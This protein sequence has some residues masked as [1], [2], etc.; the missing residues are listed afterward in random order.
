MEDVAWSH[1]K[2]EEVRKG[3]PLEASERL[4][5]CPYLELRLVASRAEGNYEV[6]VTSHPAC[7]LC[8][9]GGGQDTH[10]GAENTVNTKRSLL[11]R[12]IPVLLLRLRI[13]E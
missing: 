13:S 7:G 5:F 4:W 3:P 12:K 2:L 8:C 11:P 6:T 10:A 9:G 1:Q